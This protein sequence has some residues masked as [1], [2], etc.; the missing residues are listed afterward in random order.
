MT[1]YRLTWLFAAAA[2]LA[3]SIAQ[4][5]IGAP[6]LVWIGTYT[7][8]ASDG[9]YAFRFDPATGALTPLGLAARTPSPSFLAL[10][11][12]GRYLYAV[13]ETH[14]GPGKAG[15]VSAF[16]IDAASGKLTLLNTQASHGAD[17]CHL[18]IDAT[19]RFLVVA[20]YSSGTDAV[21][22]IAPDGRLGDAV[23]V[24]ADEGSGPDKD[25]QEGP[26]AHAVVFDHA[27]RHL[28]AVD[29]GTD[30]LLVY[31]FDAATGKLSPVDP[32]ALHVV[33]GSGPRHFAFHPDGR[34]AYAINEMASTITPLIWNA[35]A[36]VL[37]AGAP[38]STLPAGF[39]GSNTTAELALDQTGRFLYG[40][41]RGHD[42]IATF[43]VTPSG[44][45]TLVGHTSTRGKTPRHFAIDPT[46]AWLVA[47]NQD[48]GSLAVFK[49]NPATGVLTPQGDIVPVGSPVCVLFSR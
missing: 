18:A 42:S 26:H 9:I 22:P 3:L 16:A 40:S 2:L 15:S 49:V 27:N 31:R 6:R 7:G 14:D 19:G 25:R 47:A 34:R 43:K 23:G 41:N 46:G 29:L 30:Q 36:G 17:P 4:P 44:A 12:N 37:T 21:F 24:R 39:T 11:P 5:A 35:T 20:N 13:N 28:V 38:V 8:P 32:P 45:L 10:H 33:P 48:S 1:A